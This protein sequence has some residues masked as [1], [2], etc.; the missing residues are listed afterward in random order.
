MGKELHT[1][2]QILKAIENSG[3]IKT[4]VAKKLGIS[5]QTIDRY[6]RLYPS[7]AKA[8]QEEMDIVRDKAESNIFLEIQNGDIALSQWLLRYKGGY[9]EKSEH[10]VDE[11]RRIIFEDADKKDKKDNEDNKG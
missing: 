10:K 5:R 3:G 6:Q 2:K 1:V 4:N 7:I 11:V 9:V 8:L